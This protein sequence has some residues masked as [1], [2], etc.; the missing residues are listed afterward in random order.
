M[1]RPNQADVVGNL[2]RVRQQLR[3]LHAALAVRLK[4]ARAGHHGFQHPPRGTLLHLHQ[5][6]G[7]GLPVQF[8]HLRLRIEQVQMRRAA[9]HENENH[10]L[11]AWDEVRL[12]TSRG[13]IATQQ[14]PERHGAKTM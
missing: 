14:M 11:G 9:H 3:Q 7:H 13:A 6:V 12:Q 5:R 1:H 4:L 8:G 2:G 10:A